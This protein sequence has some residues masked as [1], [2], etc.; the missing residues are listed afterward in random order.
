MKPETFDLVLAS[1]TP[2][3]RQVAELMSQ[4]KTVAEMA[5][6]IGLSATRVSVIRG[7]VVERFQEAARQERFQDL[8]AEMSLAKGSEQKTPPKIQ[9]PT[10]SGR[11]REMSL[12]EIKK[13]IAALSPDG[14]ADLA[15]FI[16]F[17]DQTG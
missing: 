7:Q 13:A 3:Q 2:R 8:V 17:R 6:L 16:R 11:S 9:K 4:E 12:A 10:S 5:R 1:C 14:F 15:A